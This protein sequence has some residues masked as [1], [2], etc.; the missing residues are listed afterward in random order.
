V[1]LK[2]FP[3]S[4]LR[5]FI[6]A[7]DEM[8]ELLRVDNVD[9]DS[10]VGPLTEAI[11]ET[12][13]GPPMV[14]YDQFAGFPK[15]Y[16]LACQIM[17]S[18][19]RVALALGLDPETPKLE[20]V[21]AVTRTLKAGEAGAMPPA[22]VEKAPV[23]ENVFRGAD[24]DLLKFPSTHYQPL[25]GG[26]FLGT[27]D[28]LINRDPESGYVNVGTY[29]MQVHER[30]LLGLWMSPGQ[31]GRQVAQRY[32]D[33]GEACPVVATF[34]G[35]P[36]LFIVSQSKLPWGKSEL[37]FIGGLRKKP[38]EVIKGPITGLPIPAHAEIAIEGEVPPPSVESRE[39]GPFGEFPGYYSGGTA[40]MGGE[41]QPVIKV[42]A[43]YH[44]NDPIVMDESP[45]WPGAPQFGFTVHAGLLWDQLEGM[46]ISDITGVYIY[47]TSFLVVIAIKQK[48]PGHAKQAA[49]GALGASAVA[50]LG[51]YIVIVDDDI[52]PT[53]F[54]EVLWAMETRVDPA[55]DIDLIDGTWSTP[56]DPRMPPEKRENGDYTNSR[57]IFYAV[58]PYYYKDTY[59]PVGR[60]TPEVRQRILKKFAH[61]FEANQS[62][63]GAKRW[64]L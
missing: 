45:M 32:W 51:R 17:A 63:G 18:Y 9:R 50:R 49:F 1:G 6:A 36:L 37:D 2:G 41:L 40:G 3:H 29:R 16:R 38:F 5:T 11:A 57:A 64:P 59:P 33:K 15:G 35:D 44:R 53:N 24:V 20:L 27:G 10:E 8:G 30:D 31:Q 56:L 46:G 13:P 21:R 14:V 7:V 43:L 23:M 42:K 55:R 61:V 25:N 52:D 60:S 47:D 4:D 28:S 19:R 54:R 58:R 39:E 22:F 12:I 48:Y 34:G 62:R 26:R